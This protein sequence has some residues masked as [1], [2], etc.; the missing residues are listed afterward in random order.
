MTHVYKR[1]AYTLI[2]WLI[3]MGGISRSLYYGG[4]IIAHLIATQAYK[5]ALI[6]KI[7]M[8]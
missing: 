1:E 8:I 4:M 2:Q 7:Y 3:D 6:S 5:A